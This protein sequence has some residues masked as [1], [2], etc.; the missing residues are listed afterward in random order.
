MWVEEFFSSLSASTSQNLQEDDNDDDIIEVNSQPQARTGYD[1]V[2]SWTKLVSS[3]PSHVLLQM[4][5]L[6]VDFQE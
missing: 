2:D 6:H 1:M 4:S 3:K 5:L